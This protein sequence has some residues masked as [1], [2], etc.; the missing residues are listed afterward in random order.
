MNAIVMA[1]GMTQK[2]E[3]L[4]EISRGGY[5]SM[6][7]VGEK[8]MVQWV[9]DALNASSSVENIFVIGLPPANPLESSKPLHMLA[10]QGDMVAN[11]QEGARQIHALYP[12][13]TYALAVSSDIPLI[14]PEMVDWVANQVID[15]PA[16]L[17][18]NV[19]ERKVMEERFPT[20]RRTY[21]KLKGVELCGGDLNA[22]RIGLA[23][24]DNPFWQR[25]V[26]AR[27][28]PLRQAALVGYDTLF[29][30]L[31]NRLSLKEAETTFG[32]K[33]GITVRALMC[34]YAEIGMD[35]DKPFQLEIAEEALKNR[36]G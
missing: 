25:L 11:I 27:K 14:I 34:P 2:D 29:M 36:G 33:L 8:P 10:D 3:P 24:E 35:V 18:Y 16:D 26:E 7:P 9:V 30:L 4:Y 23:L 22:I 12:E 5:K 28:S 6:L 21:V 20:S 19:I 31:L 1:G 17:Y 15:N 13:E 32:R